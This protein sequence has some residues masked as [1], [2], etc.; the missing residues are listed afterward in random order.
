MSHDL[1]HIAD[2]LL[3]PLVGIVLILILVVCIVS[4]AKTWARAHRKPDQQFLQAQRVARQA[5]RQ[6]R[7]R[8]RLRGPWFRLF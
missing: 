1:L 3:V 4:A 5:T 7:R 8:Q 6:F 2:P